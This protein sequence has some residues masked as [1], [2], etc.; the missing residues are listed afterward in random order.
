VVVERKKSSPIVFERQEQILTEAG[1]FIHPITYDDF[2]IPPADQDENENAETQTEQQQEEVPIIESNTD[3]NNN[4]DNLEINEIA[5]SPEPDVNEIIEK[6]KSFYTQDD[7]EEELDAEMQRKI[8]EMIESVMNSAREEAEWLKSSRENVQNEFDEEKIEEN[9]E[10]LAQNV[11]E[12]EIEKVEVNEINEEIPTA[13]PRRKS[14]VE[15]AILAREEPEEEKVVEIAE[16]EK[17]IEKIVEQPEKQESI[18]EIIEIQEPIVEPTEIKKEPIQNDELSSP[19]S[20]ERPTSP[21]PSRLHLSSLEIDNLSVNALQAG[22]IV[23]SEIDSNTIVTNE[24]ECKSPQTPT[25]ITTT[26]EI[27]PGLIE[28][29]VERVRNAERAEMQALQAERAKTPAASE[30]PI[31]H[32]NI[33]TQNEEAPVRP[34]LPA[35]YDNQQATT[36]IPPS[37]YQLRDPSEDENIP[38]PSPTQQHHMHR[39]RK[40]HQKRRDS[41]SDSDFQNKDQQHRPRSRA[42]TSNDQSVLSLGSQ[43]IRACGNSLIDS[44]SQLM[45]ILRASSKDENSRDLHVA[46]MILIIIV[47]ALFLLGMGQ[48]PVHHHHW[49]FFNPPENPGR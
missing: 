10:D 27:P 18:E 19:I 13:P 22:R 6:A 33:Q 29:I 47:A 4:L 43:F 5:Q 16:L 48:K 12:S 37:F 1:L 15:E 26:I 24:F 32:Q 25:N 7:D 23:A 28:E 40:H 34:P 31:T 45:E 39:R 42:G 38:P 30:E 3:V 49:D 21:F 8:E 35:N 41:T 46:I 44:G 36:Q 20:E 2:G 9:F 17:E 11:I 14:N